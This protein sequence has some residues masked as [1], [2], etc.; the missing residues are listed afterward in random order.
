[1]DRRGKLHVRGAHGN[2]KHSSGDRDDDA[3]NNAADA[4]HGASI[5]G[6]RDA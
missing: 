3:S 4:G 1:M 2:R 6:I 5:A